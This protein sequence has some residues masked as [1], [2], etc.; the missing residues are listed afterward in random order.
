MIKFLVSQNLTFRRNRPFRVCS[1]RIFDYVRL[2]AC[3]STI[4]KVFSINSPPFSYSSID[5]YRRFKTDFGG[6][7]RGKK[8]KIVRNMNFKIEIRW[9]EICTESEHYCEFL[10]LLYCYVLKLCLFIKVVV[11]EIVAVTSCR[12]WWVGLNNGLILSLVV[13]LS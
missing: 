10:L 9:A 5:I 11:G 7:R 4:P 8:E 13:G 12:V 2:K 1:S 6:I 3:A